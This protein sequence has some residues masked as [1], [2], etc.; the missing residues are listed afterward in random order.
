VTVSAL[1]GPVAHLQGTET[2]Q[3]DTLTVLQVSGDLRETHPARACS[4][5][6]NSRPICTDGRSFCAEIRELRAGY[7]A[8]V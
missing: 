4:R 1:L 6:V 7:E 3:A 5:Q 8:A 2:A